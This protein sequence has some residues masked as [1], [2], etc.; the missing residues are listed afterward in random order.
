MP[1]LRLNRHLDNPPNLPR[2]RLPGRPGHRPVYEEQLPAD[3]GEGGEM[4]R[5]Q[6]LYEAELRLE[7]HQPGVPQYEEGA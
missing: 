1:P 6:V 2:P 3:V 5:F 7:E 4:R